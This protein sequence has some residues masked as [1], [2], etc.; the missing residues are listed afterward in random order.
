MIFKLA[1]ILSQAWAAESGHLSAHDA[2]AIPWNSILVQTIN[3]VLLFGL[4]IFFLRK[5]VKSHFI[6]R[7]ETYRD[8]VTKAE[9]AK[10][11]A[12]KSKTEIQSKLR[13]LELSATEGLDQARAQ[14][15]ELK[16]KLVREANELAAKLSKDAERSAQVEID[17]AKA[18]LRAELLSQ[19]LETSRKN[20][21]ANLG[22]A[23][24]KQLENEFA[25]K[26]QVV[27]G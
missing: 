23:E 10:V 13:R 19:A 27:R 17:R 21:G 24:Q 12:E 7:A 9:S 15:A 26:I 1:L 5:T 2:H 20:L 25:E 18:E 14:A 16:T 22:T 6:N 8:L 11:E 4:L 3:F